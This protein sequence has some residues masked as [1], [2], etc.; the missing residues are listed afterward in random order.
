L[1]VVFVFLL[2]LLGFLSLYFVRYFVY[3]SNVIP[4]PGFPSKIPLCPPMGMQTLSAPWILSLAP[5]LG[6]MCSLQWLAENIHLCICQAL[7]E[8]LRSRLYQAPVSKHLL[9]STIVSGFGD[10]IWDGSLG[11]AVSGW[12]FLQYILHTFFM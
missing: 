10:C 11:G 1:F 6:T 9:A 8:P 5:P 3:I 7:A 12:S 2:L 4:F